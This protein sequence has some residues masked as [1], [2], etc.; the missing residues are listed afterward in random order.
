M[1]LSKEAV[2][3]L[4][5]N[6]NENKVPSANEIFLKHTG[7]RPTWDIE[8]AFAEHTRLHLEAFSKFYLE[9]DYQFMAECLYDYLTKNKLK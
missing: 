3:L 2:A 5:N 9:N 8:A 6:A 1:S 4:K 7:N